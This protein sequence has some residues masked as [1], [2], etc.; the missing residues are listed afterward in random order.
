MQRIKADTL[1][2]IQGELKAEA[3]LDALASTLEDIKAN[4]F[5]SVIVGDVDTKAF[6]NT[7]HQ[8]QAEVE[9]T[10]PGDTLRDFDAKALAD[11]LAYSRESLRDTDGFKRR[12]TF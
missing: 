11:T 12:I 9:I 4:N 1:N 10:T 7:M 5:F 3:L 8:S 2:N 6:I